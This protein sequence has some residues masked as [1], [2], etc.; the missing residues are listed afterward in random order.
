MANLEDL[1]V[2]FRQS[3]PA[4]IGTERQALKNNVARINTAAGNLAAIQTVFSTQ[5]A[6]VNNYVAVGDTETDRVMA[7]LKNELR[8]LTPVFTTL[9]NAANALIA[10]MPPT[11]EF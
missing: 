3:I 8:A 11:T 1:L 4:T 10:A 9:R 7:D 2:T 5:I 6:A